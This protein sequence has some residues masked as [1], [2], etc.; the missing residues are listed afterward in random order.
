MIEMWLS[1]N[2]VLERSDCSREDGKYVIL[3]C[4][5]KSP[6]KKFQLQAK[7]KTSRTYCIAESSCTTPKVSGVYENEQ[8]LTSRLHENLKNGRSIGFYLSTKNQMRHMVPSNQFYHNNQT[9]VPYY[10]F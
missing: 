4:V 8:M 10:V 2:Y 5:K 9:K 3:Q 6:D 1:R 7:S